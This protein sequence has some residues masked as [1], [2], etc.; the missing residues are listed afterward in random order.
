MS[1]ADSPTGKLEPLTFAQYHLLWQACRDH[2]MGQGPPTAAAVSRKVKED[3][4]LLGLRPP[5]AREICAGLREEPPPGRT[6]LL[7]DREVS[8]ETLLLA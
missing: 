3:L 2:L 6:L 4:S 5:T 8:R 1:E 7:R